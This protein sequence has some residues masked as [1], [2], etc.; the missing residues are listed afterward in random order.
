MKVFRA[1]FFFGAVLVDFWE[2][3]RTAWKAT[4]GSSGREFVIKETPSLFSGAKVRGAA[5][6][7]EGRDC[8]RTPEHGV[9][10]R[11]VR[12]IMCQVALAA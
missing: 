7:G 8:R 12:T 2:A 6:A 3:Q 4:R 5:M 1:F 10:V 11:D 9:E